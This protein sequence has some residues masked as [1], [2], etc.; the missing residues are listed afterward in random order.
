M[1]M[2]SINQGTGFV[3]SVTATSGN[4][5]LTGYATVRQAK[6]TNVG[7][8]ACFVRL[9][10]TTQTAVTTDFCIN[11]AE[12]VVVSLPVGSTNLGAICAGSD[13]TTLCVSPVVATD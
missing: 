6:L 13:T 5:A 12:T 9:G 4:T 7:T 11:G 1:T 10:P 8:K 2:Y 3:V